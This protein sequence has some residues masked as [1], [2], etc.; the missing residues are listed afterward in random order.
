MAERKSQNKYYPPDWDPSKASIRVLILSNCLRGPS[1]NFKG[2]IPCG[3][4]LVN[5]TLELWL[6]DSKCHSTFGARDAQIISGKE[7]ATM[8]KRKRLV[9]ITPQL[10]T[11]LR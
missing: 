2:S 10:S 8:L 6:F 11:A 4:V 7:F 3:I 5:F 1:I 9:T